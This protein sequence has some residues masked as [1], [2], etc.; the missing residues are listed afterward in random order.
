MKLLGLL[1]NKII[2]QQHNLIDITNFASMHNG[3]KWEIRIRLNDL[4]DIGQ[5]M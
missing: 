4:F 5:K 2:E 1:D 3:D